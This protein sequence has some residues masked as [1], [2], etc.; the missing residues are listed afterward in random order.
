MVVIQFAKVKSFKGDLISPPNLFIY[1]SVYLCCL[2]FF[3]FFNVCAGKIGIQSVM[4]S[5]ILFN[6][7]IIE[8]IQFRN[9]YI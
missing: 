7:D 8:I 5:R 3:T 1:K 9:K 4:F 6:L 2:L